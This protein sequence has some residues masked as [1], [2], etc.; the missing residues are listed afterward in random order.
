MHEEIYSLCS[1]A[2]SKNPD[3]M[4]ALYPIKARKDETSSSLEATGWVSLLKGGIISDI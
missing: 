4:A 1:I 3:A 2:S